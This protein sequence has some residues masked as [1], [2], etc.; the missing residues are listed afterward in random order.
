MVKDK[1]GLYKKDVH[2]Q[3]DISSKEPAVKNPTKLFAQVFQTLIGVQVR[4]Y[5]YVTLDLLLKNFHV[6]VKVFHLIIFAT[7]VLIGPTHFTKMGYANVCL[8]LLFME[9]NVY[10]T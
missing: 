6:F 9:T 10:L 2:A 5:A 7:D 4:I 8:D 3:M 1:Y